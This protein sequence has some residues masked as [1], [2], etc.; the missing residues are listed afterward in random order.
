MTSSERISLIKEISALLR[1][2]ER[3]IINLTLKQFNFPTKKL[4]NSGA[5]KFKYILNRIQNGS[6]GQLRSL[7]THLSSTIIE[8]ELEVSFW[9]EDF[10]RIFIS[11][12][13]SLKRTA[14]LLKIELM[15]YGVSAFV[16][17]KD[18]KPTKQ[19][20]KEIELALKTCDSLVALMDKKFHL[21]KWTDQ[22]VG[23]AYGRYLLIIPVNL[24]EKPYGF[25]SKFQVQELDD[26]K[27]LAV[28]IFETLVSDNRTKEKMAY[29]LMKNFEDSLSFAR[30]RENLNLLKKSRFWDKTLYQ[31]LKE[32]KENN[33][34]IYESNGVPQG[35][36]LLLRK[37]RT[38]I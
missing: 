23:F 15:N 4:D 8:A 26:T 13:S 25:M 24:G 22:E 36:E 31:R 29:A 6:I 20:E 38:K 16:A 1:K 12:N 3:G 10:L 27:S 19:W 17:H 9:Q 2:E 21:S 7:A 5:D 34:Q 35:I 32:A 14:S 11:H 33:R 18:I 28:S 37:V 30:A